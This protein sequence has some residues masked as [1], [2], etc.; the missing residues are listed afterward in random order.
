LC[1]SEDAFVTSGLL[2]HIFRSVGGVEYLGDEVGLELGRFQLFL[3]SLD[4]FKRQFSESD[5]FDV[6]R[7][8]DSGSAAKDVV[9]EHR[10]SYQTIPAVHA[11]GSFSGH[12][13][14]L[15]VG[16]AS[17]VDLDSAVLVVE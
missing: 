12:I 1:L 10:I 16:L 3:V 6:C 14:P 9:V 8:V 15:D 13:Q 2:P 17:V 11:A 7:C 5:G 4:V